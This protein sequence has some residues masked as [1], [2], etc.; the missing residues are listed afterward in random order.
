MKN[1]NRRRGRC[2]DRAQKR[3][4]RSVPT[5]LFAAA[6]AAAAT[7]VPRSGSPARVWVCAGLS[8]RRVAFGFNQMEEGFFL[9]VACARWARATQRLLHVYGLD[10]RFWHRRIAWAKQAELTQ[11][12]ARDAQRLA[13]GEERCVRQQ[14][15]SMPRSKA[16]NSETVCNATRRRWPAPTLTRA[17]SGRCR[18][19]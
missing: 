10:P 1:G 16:T 14:N 17:S 4:T 6:A 18:V 12:A 9:S 5:P 3:F 15:W 7:T 13:A 19:A 2:N 11:F 8:Q